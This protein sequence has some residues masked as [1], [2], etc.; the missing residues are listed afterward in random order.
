[1]TEKQFVRRVLIAICI[2]ALAAAAWMLAVIVLLIFASVLSAVLL[3]TISDPL[4][5]MTRIPQGA[6]LAITVVVLFGLAALVGFFFGPLLFGELG[7]LI[8]GLP[9]AFTKLSQTFNLGSITDLFKSGDAA[10][11]VSSLAARLFT[12]S[13]GLVGA[14][15]SLLLVVMGAIYLAADPQLYRAGFVKLFPV[16]THPN[17]EATLNDAHAALQGWILG[18]LIAM[19]V[20]GILTSLALSWI[21]VPNPIALGLIVGLADFVPYI[22]PVVASIPVILV[23]GSQ[24]AQTLAWAIGSL[25]VV[26]QLESNFIVPLVAKHMV[27]IAPVVGLFAV[28]ALGVLLGPLGLMLGFPLAVV[29]DVAV[30]RLYVRDS[31]DEPVEIMGEPAEKSQ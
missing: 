7:A 14:L 17:V 16:G 4:A 15:A 19:A 24:G 23:A 6:A 2:A 9:A 25:L 12:W 20:V 22:G 8:A 29:I 3:R 18:Q 11:S 30:R 5:R 21:G 10:S 27:S 28:V 26:L 31:L 1:M 13:T